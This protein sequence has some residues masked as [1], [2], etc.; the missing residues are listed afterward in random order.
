[1]KRIK[2]MFLN[3]V[4]VA[5]IAVV[6]FAALWIIMALVPNEESMSKSWQENC[7]K[8]GGTIVRQKNTLHCHPSK[9]V[10]K[11]PPKN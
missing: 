6:F 7:S 10:A 1:M 11:M 3:E 2:A 8:N 4:F 9:W 5:T